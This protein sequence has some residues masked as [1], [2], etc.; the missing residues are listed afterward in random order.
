MDLTTLAEVLLAAR[1]DRQEIA[2]L[3]SARE[4]GFSMDDAYAVEARIAALRATQGRNV[5]GRKAGYANKAAWRILKLET[6]VW[7]SIY[8][9]TIIEA[10]EV[11]ASRFRQPR[12]EPEI[13]FKVKDSSGT[14][15]SIEWAALGFEILDNPYSTWDF[16]PADFVAAYGLHAGLIV[17]EPRPVDG[18]FVEGLAAFKVRL[19]RNGEL[20]EEGLGKNS[21]RSPALCLAELAAAGE[22]R[23]HPLRQGELISTGTLTTPTPIAAGE[24]WR[25][26]PEGLPVAPVEIQLV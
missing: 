17:G 16:K 19:M 13:I 6:L 14:A 12:I 25:A 1:T 3:P 18:A 5:V 21:L 22:R 2:E 15:D 11:P 26:E 10:G 9:D 4:G 7:A 24:V 23:G 8:D 20:V